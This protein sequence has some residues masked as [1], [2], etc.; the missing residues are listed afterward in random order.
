MNLTT[1]VDTETDHRANIGPTRRKLWWGRGREGTLPAP[2]CSLLLAKT[3]AAPD[4]QQ[5]RAD[6]GSA[7]GGDSQ[8]VQGGR[9][10]LREGDPFFLQQLEDF[11]YKET[12]AQIL[13]S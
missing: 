2:T 4:P 7:P 10:Q 1:S 6:A 5:E 9:L 3:P 8:T 12:P 11:S 13:F